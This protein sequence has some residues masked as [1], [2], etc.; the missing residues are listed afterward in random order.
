MIF[1][2]KTFLI[3]Y[4]TLQSDFGRIKMTTGTNNW[5]VE[6]YRNKLEIQFL[7]IFVRP[8]HIFVDLI[9]QILSTRT[10][11]FT[12]EVKNFQTQRQTCLK[13]SRPDKH[14]EF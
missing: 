9:L 10:E 13:N 7:L 2:T 6:I 8:S 11:N 12:I 4:L 14:Q 5:N 1:E 3:C